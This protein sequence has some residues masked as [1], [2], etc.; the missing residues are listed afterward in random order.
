MLSWR[1]LD[2]HSN[3][4]DIFRN[5]SESLSHLDISEA[6]NAP[7]IVKHGNVRHLT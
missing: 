3:T 4:H 6:N 2:R 5:E 1:T 7:Q